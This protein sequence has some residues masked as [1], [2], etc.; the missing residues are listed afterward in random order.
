MSSSGKIEFDSDELHAMSNRIYKSE[1]SL[2]YKR[3][4]EIT[5]IRSDKFSS[6]EFLSLLTAYLVNHW[7]NDE[8]FLRWGNF[9]M[10]YWNCTLPSMVL[11]EKEFAGVEERFQADPRRKYVK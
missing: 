5:R 8:I 2:R 11:T 6:V 9:R 10:G 7:D 1:I 4:E 3:I